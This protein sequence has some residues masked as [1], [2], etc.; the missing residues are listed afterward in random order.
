MG[1]SLTDI[2]LLGK[3]TSEHAHTKGLRILGKRKLFWGTLGRVIEVIVKGVP[4]LVLPDAIEGDIVSLKAFGGTE[5]RNL[6]E[7][8]TELEYIESTGTQYI[9]TGVSG[10]AT[11]KITAQASVIKGSSQALLSS[12]SG[13]SGG[14]W[15][16]E[17]TTNQKWGIGTDSGLTTLAPTTKITA[18]ITFNGSG[19][20]GTVNGES[21][22]RSATVT[23]GT[24]TIMATDA[25][26]YPFSGKVWGVQITQGGTLVRNMIPCKNASNVVGMYDTVNDVFYQNAGT[27][28]F[29]AGN[30]V[31]PIPSA[32]V[33]IWC[34]NGVLKARH[35]SGLPL[36]CVLVDGVTNTQVGGTNGYINTGIVADVDDMEFDV[37]AKWVYPG[38]VS[39]YV[40]QSRSGGTQPIYGISGSQNG[41][42]IIGSFSGTNVSSPTIVR[43]QNHTYH[44]NL[45][46]KNGNMTLFVED[47]TDNTSETTTGTYTFIAASSNIGLFSNITGGGTLTTGTTYVKSAYIKKSGVKVMDYMS[48]TQNTVAGFYD[49]VATDFVGAT[50]GGMAANPVAS[51]PTEIYTDGTV[52]TINVHGKN[53]FNGVF[54]DGWGISS[55]NGKITS[56]AGR[57]SFY[58][59]VKAG[60]TYTISRSAV[61][62]SSYWYYGT[63]QNEP[64][65]AGQSCV[66]FGNMGSSAIKYSITIPNDANYLAIF[67][68]AGTSPNTQAEKGSTA[69]DYQPYFDGGTATCEDLLSV[70]DN[71]DEQEVVGGNVTRKVGVKVLD[72]TEEWYNVTSY[73][74]SIY[75][76]VVADGILDSNKLVYSTH[77]T[78]TTASNA[79]M[80]NYTIKAVH[81]SVLA[82]NKV[83]V[84]VKDTTVGSLANFK[85]WLADQYAAGTPVIVVYPLATSTT[86]TV[87]GQPM[88]TTQGD[89]TAEIT[90][91]SVSGLELEV[92]YMAGVVLTVEEVEDAQLSP[93]VEVTIQ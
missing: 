23:Q 88:S 58:I 54:D 46:C 24:W 85:Q 19:C 49:F 69:T 84:Y 73:V 71:T 27:G 86:E 39:W 75:G 7:G 72:G 12:T 59:P 34:N 30:A 37:V 28:D 77:Y 87:T 60:Q 63:Y 83:S 76:L 20:S 70:G 15:F 57:K 18:E 50:S 51:D 38:S 32:P 1:V 2:L 5:Q 29:V 16:G 53:L 3:A 41:N 45:K 78:G 31:S 48:C 61:G 67:F 10:N 8:Y 4:P 22:T 82:P 40:L 90:Q 36:D 26:A 66:S 65:A 33:D 56:S 44:V 89:N 9:D 79:N 81:A 35:Q 74:N 13:A 52:E 68:G 17:F 6:P 25:L 21:I 14:T 80:E 55:A 11:I 93:D 43:Q 62:E 47:L 64:Y 92:T 42:T 91:A